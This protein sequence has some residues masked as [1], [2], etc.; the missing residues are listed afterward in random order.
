MN[1]E[2]QINEWLESGVINQ[3]QA[4][5]MISD[6]DQKSKEEKSSKFIVVISTIGSILLGIGAILFVAS[7]WRGMPDLVKVFILL[8]STF[9]AYYL[10]YLFKYSRE[11][12]PKVGVSLFF[13]G[14]LLFGAS[15]FLIAQIYNVNANAHVLILIWIIGIVPLIYAF[16][17]TPIAAL[18]SLLF[19]VWVALFIFRGLRFLDDTLFS[20][21]VIYLA[22]GT[23]LFGIGGIHYLKPQLNK[24]ARIF[25]ISGIKIAMLSLFLLTFS[26]FSGDVGG[27]FRN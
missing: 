18:S 11:N 24:I 15:I 21:P 19:F 12:L 10:G 2:K 17:S 9:G 25:R 3:E 5:K 27:W 22:A 26:F 8:V 1:N 23:L 16:R 20:Y 14:A 4:S 7:N 6:V 13:L